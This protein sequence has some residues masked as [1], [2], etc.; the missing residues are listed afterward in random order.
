MAEIE[1]TWQTPT[2]RIINADAALAKVASKSKWGTRIKW[3]GTVLVVVYLI[4]IATWG[5]L[6]T[7]NHVNQAS[8]QRGAQQTA[9][10]AQTAR[11]VS[12]QN[13]IVTLLNSHTSELA[14]VNNSLTILKQFPT[15]AQQTVATQQ[16]ITCA[17]TILL[18]AEGKPSSPVPAYCS[19]YYK[20]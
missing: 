2:E 1:D 12:L 16:I 6:W 13:N 19:L 3:V 18:T 14:A 7:I 17:V 11:I 15:A 8:K 20:P 10:L 9:T 5:Q 4:T